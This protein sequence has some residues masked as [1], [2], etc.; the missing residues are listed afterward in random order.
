VQLKAAGKVERE[1][2]ESGRFLVDIA[3]MR[4]VFILSF[5]N[6]S[7]GRCRCLKALTFKGGVHPLHKQHEGKN[8]SKGEAL[9]EYV[10]STVVIP[11]SQHIGAPCTPCVQVGDEVKMGQKIG[12]P[13]GFVSA[14]IH[15]SV[16]GKVVAVEPRPHV[17][18]MKVLSV[19][20]ENDGKDTLDESVQPKG[21]LE[22]LSADELKKI[23]VEAGIV[24]MGGAAFPTHVKYA[25]KP[26]QKVDYLIINGAECE[27]YLTSDHRMMLENSDKIARGVQLLKKASGAPVA[28]IGIENNKPDAIAAMKKAVEGK[29]GLKV[30]ELMTKYP[31]GGEKQLIFAITGREVPKGALPIAAGCI[32]SNVSTAAAMADAVELG[33]PLIRRSVTI[34]G[35]VKH[36]GNYL[37]RVGTLY[38]DIFEHCGGFD[39]EPTKII[40]GGPMMG[41]AV[42]TA[43]IPVTKGTSGLTVFSAREDKKVI[44]SNCI[45]CGRCVDICPMGLRPY[46]LATAGRKG[47]VEV[48]KGADVLSCINCGS[49]T[50]ICPAKRDLA[51]SIA[52]G[53]RVLAKAT[54]KK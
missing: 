41:L 21:T 19:V 24:G 36:P 35:A 15:A 2:P 4:T 31:Q 18:G 50:F 33:M 37:L 49:C 54:P 12:E 47:N 29:E 22:S 40:S 30:A 6:F 43:E 45:R 26:E 9:K 28:I 13:G 44:E 11:M 48:L 34:T 7:E 8:L 20:I 16:S 1:D 23:M 17:S 53:K 5:P 27:P 39:G 51:Q 38:S 10:A 42:A 46:L 32:V 25:V 3:R 14:P 52:L